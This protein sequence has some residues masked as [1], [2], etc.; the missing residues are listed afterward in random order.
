MDLTHKHVQVFL[1]SCNTA[2]IEDVELRALT[3][4]EGLQKKVERGEWLTL[5]P[6]WVD[7]RAQKEEG[8]Q[9]A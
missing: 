3:E 6:G 8:L 7:R 1:Q 4:F 9:K 2:A 5:A